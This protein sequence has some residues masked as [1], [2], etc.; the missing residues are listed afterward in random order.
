MRTLTNSVPMNPAAPVTNAVARASPV[1][2][3]VWSGSEP[4]TTDIT[5]TG[6]ARRPYRRASKMNGQ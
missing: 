4:A 2:S 5:H 6:L 1:M 3:S